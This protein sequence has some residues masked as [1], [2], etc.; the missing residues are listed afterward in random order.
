[1]AAHEVFGMDSGAGS[2]PIARVTLFTDPAIPSGG[3]PA[4]RVGATLSHVKATWGLGQECQDSIKTERPAHI[5][6]PRRIL[7]TTAPET[8][9]SVP[10]WRSKYGAGRVLTGQVTHGAPAHCIDWSPWYRGCHH[11]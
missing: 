7:D 6:W 5:G 8:R 2:A 10:R 9:A 1:M 3:N 4:Y 11:R